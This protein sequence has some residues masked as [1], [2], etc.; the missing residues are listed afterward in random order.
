MFQRWYRRKIDIWYSCK[1]E[2]HFIF[3]LCSSSDAN[4]G[5]DSL[6]L[7]RWL[8]N[9]T[10]QMA[11]G[12]MSCL[13]HPYAPLLSSA[14]VQ[15]QPSGP[16]PFLCRWWF[17]CN[18]SNHIHVLY[19]VQRCQAWPGCTMLQPKLLMSPQLN[20]PGCRPFNGFKTCTHSHISSWWQAC[21]KR[22]SER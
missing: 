12:L 21:A 3:T 8:G 17:G 16:N 2:K 18:L 1:Q 4:V 6:I 11:A 20:P 9:S 15:S 19:R 5:W 13:R 22:Y 10:G 7:G 14:P